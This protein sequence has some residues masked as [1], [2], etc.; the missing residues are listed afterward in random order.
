MLLRPPRSTRTDTLV[1]SPTLFRSEG[2][3]Q[4]QPEPWA[5]PPNLPLPSQG[6]GPTL[7]PALPAPA[8]RRVLEHDPF[9][10]ELVADGVGA[11]EVAG[12]FR[13]PA[14]VDQ[15][16]DAGVAVPGCT[17]DHPVSRCRLQAPGRLPGAEQLALQ[18]ASLPFGSCLRR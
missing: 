12:P 10:R 1:P 15:R 3:R 9:G 11:G 17:A 4:D 13:R 7:R 16:L 6:E 8:L 2:C 18:P 14:L 5:P